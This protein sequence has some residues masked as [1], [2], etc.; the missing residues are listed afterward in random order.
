MPMCKWSIGYRHVQNRQLKKLGILLLPR[1]VY[2][3]DEDVSQMNKTDIVAVM[4]RKFEFKREL[5]Q[6]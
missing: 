5:V 4:T 1:P 2:I 3:D 6:E